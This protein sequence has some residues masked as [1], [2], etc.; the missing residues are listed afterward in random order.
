M[1]SSTLLDGR[2]PEICSR[3]TPTSSR[4]ASH[5]FHIAVV[6]K[7]PFA[8]LLRHHARSI[9]NQK[10]KPKP[11]FKLI[12]SFKSPFDGTGGRSSAAPRTLETAVQ[13]G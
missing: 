5:V 6:F 13:L 10:L 2:L 7:P 3:T 11:N 8:A 9:A 12:R 4:T 1:N